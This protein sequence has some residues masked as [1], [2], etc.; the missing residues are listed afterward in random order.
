MWALGP[1][2]FIFTIFSLVE[3]FN[4]RSILALLER[5]FHD[6]HK[7]IRAYNTIFFIGI[8]LHEASRYLMAKALRV[9]TGPFDPF[10]KI[11]AD[12]V[13]GPGSWGSGRYA[14]TGLIKGALIDLAPLIT[15]SAIIVL[16]SS[17]YHLN[18]L[19]F[20]ATYT[21]DFVRI[22]DAVWAMLR[23][24]VSI[25]AIPLLFIIT[26]TMLPA[27]WDGKALAAL[28]VFFLFLAVFAYMSLAIMLFF[29][30]LSFFDILIRFLTITF[31]LS[32]LIN[33]IFLPFLWLLS[34][35]KQSTDF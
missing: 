1:F 18:S 26:N 22:L 16:I 33:L 27:E 30:M 19:W 11:Q 20:S 13:I 28:L 9:Q 23:Q 12:T 21:F 14:S 25:I 3:R 34:L 2:L 31:F 7:T 17:F 5:I 6:P 15:G 35:A 32:T 8:L 29:F 10:P 4:R 24:P